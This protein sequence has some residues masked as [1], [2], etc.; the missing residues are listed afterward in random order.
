MPAPAALLAA[1]ERARRGLAAAVETGDEAGVAAFLNAGASA[2]TMTA[3]HSVLAEAIARG[4]LGVARLL[5]DAGA[6]PM[7]RRQP[8]GAREPARCTTK[9]T[10]GGAVLGMRPATS[11]Y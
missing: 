8:K 6:A 5:L 7:A 4:H 9:A 2:R 11:G 3:E 10:S 1:Q